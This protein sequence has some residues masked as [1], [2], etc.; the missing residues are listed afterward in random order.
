[1]PT[2]TGAPPDLRALINFGFFGVIARPL[3][4]WLKWTYGW[5]QNWGWAIVIQTLVI[6]LALLPLRVSSMK[7][8]LKMQKVAPQIK[9]IQEKYKKYSMRDPRKQE[10]NQEV[11]ALYKAEGV[12]PVGGCLPM[13]IQMP[14]LF[15]YYSM[16]GAGPGLAAGA[17]ALDPRSLFA[18]PVASVAHWNYHHHAADATHDAAAGHGP[19]A[20]KDDDFHDAADA[21]RDQLEPGRRACACTGPRA[22]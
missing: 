7:S 12:N 13:V 20:A 5:V 8:A 4:L 1:V 6:N 16:L 19:V 21:G 11:S 10:M 22:T 17:L 2:L 3:F 15:A 9:A 18:R 14:F